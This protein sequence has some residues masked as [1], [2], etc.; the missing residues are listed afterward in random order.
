MKE[1]MRKITA[2]ALSAA[3]IITAF[4]GCGEKKAQ[5]VA[6]EETDAAQNNDDKDGREKAEE[7][8]APEHSSTSGKNETVYVIKN[9]DGTKKTIVSA[10]LKNPSG[11]ASMKDVTCLD[12]IEIVKGEAKL[13]KNENGNVTWNAAGAD[14][15]YSG[16]T[17]KSA[18]VDVD[19]TYTLEGAKLKASDLK[20]KRLHLLC[21]CN[22]DHHRIFNTY[23][24]SDQKICTVYHR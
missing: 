10:W 16:T 1:N 21:N 19:I 9:S 20:G 12:N 22:S 5:P 13:E 8:A 18:P 23:D 6:K 2:V 4:T 11:S 14:V 15:Y 7:M 24:I 17:E 3:M